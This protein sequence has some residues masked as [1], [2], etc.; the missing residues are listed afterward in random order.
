[1][2]SAENKGDQEFENG[3][4]QSLIRVTVVKMHWDQA[5]KLI[6]I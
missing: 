3:I 5:L 1:M 4:S 2:Y 6:K